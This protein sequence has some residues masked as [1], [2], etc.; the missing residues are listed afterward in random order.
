MQGIK[1]FSSDDSQCTHN[2][3]SRNQSIFSS[4]LTK[5]RNTQLEFSITSTDLPQLKFKRT[6]DTRLSR[7]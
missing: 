6:S 1:T 4:S 5:K 2:F 3:V 7:L